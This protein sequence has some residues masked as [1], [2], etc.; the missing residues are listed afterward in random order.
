MPI[1]YSYGSGLDGGEMV[2]QGWYTD[3]AGNKIGQASASQELLNQY[4]AEGFAYLSQLMQSGMAPQQ[5]LDELVKN[6]RIDLAF[7]AAQNGLL[8]HDLTVNTSLL[9]INSQAQ[10]FLPNGLKLGEW[11]A[12]QQTHSSH[13]RFTEQFLPAAAMFVGAGY[14]LGALGAEAGAGAGLAEGAGVYGGLDAG[15]IAGADFVGGAAPIISNFSP[16]WLQ[17]LGVNLAPTG[18]PGLNLLGTGL[19]TALGLYGAD[20]QKDALEDLA[21]QQNAQYQ[22]NLA[23][24]QPYRDQLSALLADP[25]SYLKS[26][27]VTGS[28][29]QGTDALAAALSVNGNPAGSGAALH[30][31]QNYATTQYGNSFMD[32]V[33]TLGNLGG[34]SAFNQSAAQGPNLTPATSA[35]NANA[36]TYHTLGYG[37]EGALNAFGV[38]A[39]KPPTNQGTSIEQLLKQLKSQGVTL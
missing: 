19:S 35:I 21:N 36:N 6:D 4:Q 16:P 1:T 28:V 33:K 14:G 24:G 29:Q 12:A 37:L 13:D 9:P 39:Q 3:E 32:Y 23:M 15:A 30:A 18:T 7:H 22:Q 26:P 2:N 5:V 31:L 25:E 38:G 34:L 10:G 17:G 27:L 11:N 8:P 20:Q